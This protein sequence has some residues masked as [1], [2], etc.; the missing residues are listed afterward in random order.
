M[1][2]AYSVFNGTVFFDQQVKQHVCVDACNMA[3]G[4]FCQGDW[5][6]TLFR[7]DMPAAQHL[8]ID[9]KEVCAVVQ[10]VSRWAPLWYGKNVIVHT[11]S[12]VTKAIISEGHSAKNTYINCLLR[13]M[14][15]TQL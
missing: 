13:K 4:A 12:T 6:Y 14:C 5:M 1:A 9:C 10:A 3:A 11:D 8:H 2:S 15:Q 7:C